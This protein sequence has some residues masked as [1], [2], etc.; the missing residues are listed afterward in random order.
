MRRSHYISLFKLKLKQ[1]TENNTSFFAVL[2][3]IYSYALSY[4]FLLLGLYLFNFT[5]S[6]LFT[7]FPA[8]G[9]QLIQ[10]L[11]EDEAKDSI[12]SALLY[13]FVVD[14][15][16]NL[17]NT[18][19]D[20]FRA[21]L[22]IRLQKKMQEEFYKSLLDKDM[23]YYDSK[24]VGDLTSKFSYDLEKIKQLILQDMTGVLSKLLTMAGSFVFMLNLSTFASLYSYAVDDSKTGINVGLQG[25]FYGDT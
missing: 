3:R 4:P 2:V 16:F 15:L 13:R 25:L 19:Q 14:I 1:Y 5:S 20:Y 6:I 18:L 12:T 22:D 9:E 8:L 11:T 17:S 23:G 24:K 10:I 7:Y 21:Q